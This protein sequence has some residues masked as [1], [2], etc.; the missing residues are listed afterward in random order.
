MRGI[1]G[2]W[3]LVNLFELLLLAEKLLLGFIL[4]IKALF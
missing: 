4:E 2:G 3:W 1:W